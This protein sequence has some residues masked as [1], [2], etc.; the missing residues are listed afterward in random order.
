MPVWLGREGEAVH[1][2]SVKGYTKIGERVLGGF[3]SHVGHVS[4][5]EEQWRRFGRGCYPD[6]VIHTARSG[7]SQFRLPCMVADAAVKG[8]E[9]TRFGIAMTF[10]RARAGAAF[11]SRGARDNPAVW[12][13]LSN[14]VNNY[15]VFPGDT[16]SHKTALACSIL[17]WITR[18]ESGN[19]IPTAD[20][21]SELAN[22]G[23]P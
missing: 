12:E 15:P 20:G 19:W 18:D 10:E 5:V 22:K 4:I 3:D 14:V 9:G 17:G 2:L 1:G 13:E 8:D 11:E 16:I 7:G 23:K 21:V 6:R